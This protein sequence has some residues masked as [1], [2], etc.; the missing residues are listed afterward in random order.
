M[1][2][3]RT[4]RASDTT[5]TFA[6]L[7][8]ALAKGA[9]S[10]R[11]TS[12]A[13]NR[14]DVEFTDTFSKHHHK[15]KTNMSSQLKSFSPWIVGLITAT[16]LAG[17]TTT[18]PYTGEQKTSNT[19]KDAGIGAVAGAILGAATAS[20]KDRTQGIL[21][22]AAIGGGIGA[23]VGH[24][25]D[26]QEAELRKKMQNT[27][28]EVQREGDTINLVVPSAISFATDSAQLTPNFYGP[29]N[30]IATSLKDY[31]DTTVQIVGHT[32]STG[33]AAYNQ[34]LS[35]NRANAVVVYLT[36]QGVDQARM[37]ALGMGE[38]QPVADNKTAAG[39]AQN[40]R[41]EIKIIPRDN[42]TNGGAPSSNPPSG[43]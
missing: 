39:R 12:T 33:S 6:V 26:Q 28:V 25:Q 17:C 19:A 13:R 9:A 36:A 21:T 8:I 15:R 31:P 3:D 7:A 11:A 5:R 2:T 37:Q 38:S 14:A 23:A 34:Q 29:L 24:H 22:G 41:V 20:K 1:K 40:R 10:D 35:V 27:G 42:S 18:D 4:M 30:S 16:L 43:Y 32:D